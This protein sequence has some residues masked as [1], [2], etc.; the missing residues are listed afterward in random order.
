MSLLTFWLWKLFTFP[1]AYLPYTALHT[2]GKAIGTAI[3][4][5]YPKYR[6]RALCNLFLAIDLNLN[7]KQRA[8]IAK[9]SIQNLMIT[10][11]EY[12]KLAI[13]KQIHDVAHCENP[14]T[15]ISIL[16]SGKGV[17]FFCGHQ[18]N[19]EVLFLEGT[20]RMPGVAIGRPIKNKFL[21]R[22]IVALREK[23]GGKIVTPH[24]AL[25]E[26]LKALKQCC[27]V[28]IVG[29]QGRPDSGF[30]YPIFGTPAW[31]SPFPAHLSIQTGCP[32]IVA[33]TRREHGK[34]LIRYSDPLWP[35]EYD[36]PEQLMKQTIALLEKTIA[37]QPGQW[38]WTHNCWKQ[39][40]PGKLR[41]E[42]RHES[43]A[44]ILPDNQSLPIM[45]ALR[46]IYP[47]E[48]ITLFPPDHLPSL[49]QGS[50]K[51]IFN[52][53]TQPVSHP[54]AFSIVNLKQ[55]QKLAPHAR[56]PS[57]LLKQAIYARPEILP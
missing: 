41:P 56:T 26:S 44:V 53:T 5:L 8:E 33:S 39:Q 21:Y 30:S 24:K 20:S 10:V 55:L 57:D 6:K 37:E 31:T 47:S 52:F 12:P 18:A 4:Y 29:D 36:N 48:R 14:D 38:L 54:D 32:I 23:F 45:A 9:Q 35:G 13:T 17:I 28:G 27:F 22:W 49:S 19:W 43:I 15:A 46:D 3:Y 51:L 11:L 1:L 34:Y 2:L 7:R 25:K 42:F 50:Y 16:K 40:L